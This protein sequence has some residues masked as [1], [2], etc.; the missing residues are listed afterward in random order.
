MA[1]TMK[2]NAYRMREA[3]RA[4]NTE[5]VRSIFADEWSKPEIERLQIRMMRGTGVG[6][7]YVECYIG[8]YVYEWYID[9]GF[10]A[11]GRDPYDTFISDH[12]YIVFPRD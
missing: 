2:L 10:T 7:G 4:R 1:E 5:D 12:I 6:P 11:R 8:D 3:F 9:D